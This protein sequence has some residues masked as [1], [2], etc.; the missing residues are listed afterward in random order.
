MFPAFLTTIFFAL[1]AIFASRSARMLGA[2]TANLG[3]MCVALLLLG[4]WAHTM[5]QGLRGASLGY[6][7]ASGLIGYGLGDIGL[8]LALTRIGPRLT[9]ML[10]HCLAVPCAAVAEKLWLGTTMTA[11]QI[12]CVFVTLAGVCI[13]LTPIHRHNLTRGMF[14]GGTFFGI[15]AS[16]GQA[17]GAVISRKAYQVAALSGLHMDGGT[18]AY[19]RMIGGIII[20]AS[21]A[22]ATR[23]FGPTKEVAGNSAP[24]ARSS[25]LKRTAWV[26]VVLNAIVGPALGVACFQWALSIS[27]SGIVLPIV[28]TTP[29]VTIPLAYWMD[30]DRPSLRSLVGGVIAVTG[31][32]ALALQA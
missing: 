15:C 26:F 8:F 20:G 17:G 18:A 27:P 4:A 25:E 9:M 6:F 31:T 24:M 7:L 19:Q 3:R 32:V 11:G 10:V 21:F 29:V 14:L 30:G 22:M 2:A 5:G 28:A 13:A 16:L 1:S 23:F 12:I